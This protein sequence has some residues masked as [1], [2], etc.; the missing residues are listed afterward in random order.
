MALTTSEG[1]EFFRGDLN[2]VYI[3][4]LDDSSDCSSYSAV[5]PPLA[6][7]WGYACVSA[8]NLRN[9][10]GSGW[11]PVD[12]TNLAISSPLSNL[13][14]DPVNGIR[15]GDGLYYYVY[16]PGW[17]LIAN[18]ES[19]KFEFGGGDDIES[20][21]GGDQP[22]LYEVG[23]LTSAPLE[24]GEWITRVQDPAS[25]GGDSNPGFFAEHYS[26]W[27]FS[28]SGETVKAHRIWLW[29]GN[30]TLSTD[31]YLEMAIYTDTEQGAGDPDGVKISSTAIVR[32]TDASGWTS[33][34]FAS[35]TPMISGQNYIIGMGPSS[36]SIGN[37]FDLA[38][39]WSNLCDNYLPKINSYDG[40]IDGVLGN[41]AY[42]NA[43]GGSHK[44]F[45]GISYIKIP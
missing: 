43:I 2:T 14:V 4:L 28:G 41:R 42:D 19:K 35:S 3:S 44:G 39:D 30:G 37:Y 1:S 24:S 31:E 26:R 21:D 27:L 10:D 5:I 29:Q 17:E 18:M 13:P 23:E 12:F 32:G 36:P 11:I 7:P 38:S 6:S 22:H 15:S 25:C 9:V 20:T 40:S 34:V 16:V 8:S 33:G 45:P